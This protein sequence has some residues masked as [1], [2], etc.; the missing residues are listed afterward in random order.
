MKSH[1]HW[2]IIC[3]LMK[4]GTLHFSGQPTC[5][6]MSLM[7]NATTSAVGTEI[8]NINSYVKLQ[9]KVLGGFKAPDPE[10]SSGSPT[11]DNWV[12]TTRC[13]KHH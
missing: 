2:Y 5:V 3:L 8:Y 9:K 13:R 4:G 1:F 12:G 10:E 6:C 11:L 7:L